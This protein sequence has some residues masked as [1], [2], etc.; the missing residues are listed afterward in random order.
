M[1]LAKE[2]VDVGMFT[3]RLE[4]MRAFWGERIR[5]PYEE[6]LPLGG[7][8]QQ[9]RYGLA[10]SVL[11]INTSRDLLPP[12]RASGY[13]RITIA[14][15]RLPMP[16]SLEDPEGTAVELVPS[17]QRGIDQIE[18]LIG[19]TDPEAHAKFYV[20]SL[21]AAPLGGGRFKIGKTIVCVGKD[22][23]AVRAAA[24]PAGSAN[25]VMAAMRACGFRYITIQVRDCDREHRR[26]LAAGAWEGSAP[27]T[28]GKVARI[29]FV[30]DPDGNFIEI[31]QRASLTGALPD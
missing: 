3:N 8:M 13:S 14:D 22:P 30:R 10:G 31:S 26:M 7:G 28:L 21:Q 23:N 12:R 25:D 6:L 4:E 1:E 24:A 9:H 5:L 17:G 16:M 11:K 27:M 2:C 20:D 29:S 18:I 19:V 15:R